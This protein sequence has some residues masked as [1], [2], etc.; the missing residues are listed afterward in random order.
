MQI[1][2]RFIFLLFILTWCFELNGQPFKSLN[3]PVQINQIQIIFPWIGGLNTP[4]IMNVD[5]NLDKKMDVVIFD[6]SGG[7][8]IPFIWDG[9]KLVYSPEYKSIFPKISDWVIS[10]DYNG[11][12][13]AD[14]FTYS[15]SP[16]IAGVDVYD[17][18]IVNNALTY[19]K[20]SFPTDRANILYYSSGPSRLNIYVSNADYPSVEDVDHDGD[21]DIL[22][23]EPAGVQIIWYKNMA[24]EKS[25][26][27]GSLDFIIGDFCY[28]KI[29]EDGFSELI[30]LSKNKD[31]CA[32]ALHGELEVRH[33][34]STILSWDRDQD[35]DYDLLIGD[36]SSS[37]LIF[38][39]NGGD[40]THA[41]MDQQE[42]KFPIN[43]VPVDIPY[44][45]APF[46]TDVN[47]DGIKEIFGA[48]NFQYG[49]D[50]YHCLWRY[51]RDLLNPQNYNYTSNLFIVD[52]SIDMGEN[53]YPAIVDVTGDGLLDIVVGSGGY[54]DRGGLH[55]ASMFFFK[56]TGTRTK[57][58]FQLIDSNWLDFR[59]FSSSSN[60]FAP[61]FG[62]LDGDGDLDLMIGEV[63]GQ[64]FYAENIAGKNKPM[65]FKDIR[66]GYNNIDV[67]QY[68]TPQIEDLDGD[69]L[70]DL[71]VGER[72]G[73]LNYFKNIGSVSAPLFSS[74]PTI[75]PLGNIDTRLTGYATGN[76]A[77][78]IIHSQKKRFL[79]IGTS[80]RELLLYAD[81]IASANPLNL[82][83]ASWGM[84]HEGDNVHPAVADIDQDGKLD[85]LVG[86]QRGG[87]A[88]YQSDLPSD[89]S[90]AVV[91]ID[92]LNAL[93]I[94]P[95]PA[96]DRCTVSSNYSDL[97]G[98]LTLYQINGEIISKTNWN[99]TSTELDLTAFPSGL[100]IVEL[101]NKDKLLRQK[102]MIM[103]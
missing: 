67:G 55:D 68:S 13:H 94:Y 73:V 40:S 96:R 50:N 75:N 43:S 32:S 99:Q 21:I 82:F 37:G 41:Y 8:W 90:T 19:K 18:L 11:D 61:A 51:D 95:N 3:L 70:N 9:T 91:N 26:P 86:N 16:G 42:I 93:T 46:L 31:K 24:K 38:L 97:K 78:I 2:K 102:L 65:V 33:S 103:K 60:S 44:F 76:A 63:L 72:D 34:G 92:P 100:Y 49:S 28:G 58:A 83:S 25:L 98:I 79:V 87:L 59:R 88:W 62:D 15:T 85:I 47:N 89:F 84:V 48:S 22:S 74:V 54:F 29:L 30:T 56:N 77:P 81:P 45:V 23:Y 101:T 20:H 71:L 4:Q 64:L 12:G 17:A 10:K 5:L 69:G 53:T 14:L 35:R 52:Q 39:N 36:I 66:E 7:V 1:L 80:G 57:P 6:R 27:E